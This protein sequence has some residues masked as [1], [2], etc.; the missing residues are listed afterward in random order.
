[1]NRAQARAEL[2]RIAREVSVD[3]D[4]GD[5]PM[6]LIERAGV[7]APGLVAILLLEGARTVLREATAS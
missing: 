4:E 3:H 6:R 2:G 5:Q 7:V 1:M